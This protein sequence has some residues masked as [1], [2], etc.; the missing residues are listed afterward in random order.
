MNALKWA[1]IGFAATAIGSS[2]AASGGGPKSADDLLP[3]VLGG[4]KEIAKPMEVKH[5]EGAI[6]AASAQDAANA[7]VKEAKERKT[8]GVVEI[9]FPSGMGYV[10]TGVAGYERFDNDTATSIARRNAY[11]RAFVVAKKELTV[12]LDGLSSTGRNA[13]R[14]SLLNVNLPKDEV[15]NITEESEESQKQAAGMLLEGFVVYEVGDDVDAHRVFVSIV[16][17]PKTRKQL[18]R[19]TH[20]AMAAGDLKDALNGVLA[21][22]RAGV[23]P[24]VGG[25]IVRLPNG[26]TALVGYGSAIV[27]NSKNA[28]LKE[29]LELDAQKIANMRAVDSLV[30]L[31]AGDQTCWHGEVVEKQKQAVKEF[32]TAPDG[33]V[34]K[35]DALRTSFL[36]TVESNDWYQNVR[37]GRL[38]PGT[39]DKGWIDDRG[40]W[41]FSIRIYSP[42][43]EKAARKAV[44]ESS[45][46]GADAADAG[47]EKKSAKKPLKQGPTGKVGSDD[48]K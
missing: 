46:L 45:G 43:L 42:S 1:A 4:P 7:A 37:Q 35:L 44:A 15:T 3:P 2:V 6:K 29:K 22:L 23:V 41:A 16:T 14:Q 48:D 26:E 25:R 32:E 18:S 11:V 19:I 28:T 34:K 24:P 33:D 47:G 21:E 39:V 38:P 20:H 12:K 36:S 31:L 30:G 9:R 5:E 27:R 8:Q 40:E 10:A 13:I 17:T